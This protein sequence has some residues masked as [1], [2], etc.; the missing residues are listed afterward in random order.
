MKNLLVSALGAMLFLMGTI[1]FGKGVDRPKVV[2]GIVVDQGRWDYMYNLQ[3]E[4]SE[5][6][7]K[8]LLKQG[9]TMQNARVNYLPSHTAPG[10]SSIWSGSVPAMHGIA[11][12][13]FITNADGILHEATEDKGVNLI[14][15]SKNGSSSPRNLMV[16]TIGDEL[17]LSNNFKS[18][19][20]SVA[21][22]DRGSVFPGG[23]LS[24]GSYWYDNEQGRFTT[25]TYYMN[26]L[27]GWLNTFNGRHMDD[28]LMKYEWNIRSKDLTMCTADMTSYEENWPGESQPIFP[29]QF[30]GLSRKER[31]VAFA[32]SP[33]GS[34]YTFMMARAMIEGEKIGMGNFTDVLAISLSS[35]D[36]LAH[37]FGMNSIEMHEMMVSLD[38]DIA[39]FLTY[40]DNTYGQDNYLLFLTADHGGSHNEEYMKDVKVPAGIIPKSL[41]VDLNTYLKDVYGQDSIV[42]AITNYYNIFLRNSVVDKYNLKRA[43]IRSSIVDWLNKQSYTMYAVDLH[44]INKTAMPSEIREMVIRG[45][46]RERCGDVQ[47]IPRAGW[48]EYAG[49]KKGNTHGTWTAADTHIPMIFFGWNVNPGEDFTEVYTT[50]I[51]PTVASMLHIQMPNGCIGKCIPT[52][53]GKHAKAL[54]ASSK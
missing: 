27:P 31:S 40:L 37:Q 38:R 22:K 9:H 36:E 3:D 10:H 17:R 21:L 1:S 48:Y 47:I 19:T 29:H 45:Y 2:V 43:D 7:F 50:D 23:H 11:G 16:T 52:V 44:D 28:T 20:F 41:V 32:M 54:N 4:L 14:G 49:K 33:F 46:V 15:S 42:Q 35:P 34:T 18:R 13:A 8:R 51:A 6:G 30:S 5:G 53:I 12:N 26:E 39:T 24:N 25:S